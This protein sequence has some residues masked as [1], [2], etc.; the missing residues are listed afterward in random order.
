VVISSIYNNTCLQTEAWKDALI[1]AGTKISDLVASIALLFN[2]IAL[3]LEGSANVTLPSDKMGLSPGTCR[4]ILDEAR[5]H[6]CTHIQA[7]F[8]SSK[9]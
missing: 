2:S 9:S 8:K 7:K 3:E 1:V 4:R 6:K 5:I